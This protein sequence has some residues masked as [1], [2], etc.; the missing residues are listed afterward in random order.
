MWCG[1]ERTDRHALAVIGGD[2]ASGKL[3]RVAGGYR[4]QNGNDVLVNAGT[5]EGHGGAGNSDAIY[6]GARARWRWAPAW[7]ARSTRRC[8]CT[9]GWRTPAPWQHRP[10]GRAGQLGVRLRW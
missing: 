1:D 10:G 6:M 7:S 8:R 3:L 2:L 4:G 5:V 9:A